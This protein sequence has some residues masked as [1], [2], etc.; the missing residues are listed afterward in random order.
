VFFPDFFVRGLVGFF[1]LS[2][3]YIRPNFR[4]FET[5]S[6]ILLSIHLRAWSAPQMFCSVNFSKMRFKVE[7]P[8]SQEDIAVVSPPPGLSF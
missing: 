3:F 5:Q 8:A 4:S 6:P 7:H 1:S 2:G